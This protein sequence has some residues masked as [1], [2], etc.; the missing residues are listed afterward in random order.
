MKPIRS[1]SSAGAV[2]AQTVGQGVII[3]GK[4]FW[5]YLLFEDGRGVL[6]FAVEVSV[7]ISGTKRKSLSVDY[8]NG[9]E[10]VCD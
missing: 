10:M 5:V 2:W 7:I 8:W 1:R 3:I 9:P 6:H 4:R